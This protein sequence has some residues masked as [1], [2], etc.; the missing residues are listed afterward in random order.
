MSNLAKLD[1]VALDISCN[2]YLS[3]VLDAEIHLDANGLG[4]TIKEGNTTT[5]QNKAKAMIFLHH[6]LCEGLKYEY[7][8]VKDPLILWKNLKE[9]I[10]AQLELRGEK[11][12]DADMLEKTYQTFHCSQL[13]LS[14][15]YRQRGFKRYSELISC[16]LVAEQN[17][18]IWLKNHQSRLTNTDPFPKVNAT[19]YENRNKGHTGIRGLGCGRGRENTRVNYRDGRGGN[20]KNSYFHQKNDRKGGPREAPR[21]GSRDRDI[22]NFC[23]RCGNKGHWSRT[24]RAP[25]HVVDSYHRSLNDNKGKKIEANFVA[26]QEKVETNFAD[27]NENQPFNYDAFTDPKS[28]TKSQIPAVNALA[29]VIVPEGLLI[30]NESKACLKRGRPA[31]SKDKNPRKQKGAKVDKGNVEENIALKKSPIELTDMTENMSLEETQVPEN[32]ECEEISINYVMS[33][34]I[35]NRN[36]IDVDDGVFTFNVAL[37]I[38]HDDEDHESTSVDQC[39]RRID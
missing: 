2:N 34:K 13:L 21:D 25:P 1:F 38:M 10:T 24:C 26:E 17:N 39:R 20:F 22:V 14:Q 32:D 35:W 11:V 27:T 4:E 7:L 12:S 30:A 18:E 3:W 33:R 9:R 15:Q 16:L 23:H 8:T 29:K 5:T 37:D 31:D 36:E 28:V 19:K 6:Q